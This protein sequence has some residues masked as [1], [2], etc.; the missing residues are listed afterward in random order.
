[1]K[2][3]LDTNTLIASIFEQNAAAERLLDA[4]HDFCVALL[5]LMELRTVL[6]NKKQLEQSR[7][8]QI[9]DGIAARTD[10]YALER[11][12]ALRAYRRQTDALL[13]PIDCLLFSLANGL[14]AELVTFDTELQDAGAVAPGAVS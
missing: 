2:L 8:E 12:D 9:I 4:D 14:D 3:L 5:S 10:V 1:M 6:T 7:V 13:Y 11:E